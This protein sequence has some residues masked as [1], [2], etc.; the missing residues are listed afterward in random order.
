M[1][2]RIPTSGLVVALLSASF[3]LP[4]TA[5]AGNGGTPAPAP[6]A[7]GQVDPSFLLVTQH[8]LFVGGIL[9]I[10]G[11]AADAANHQVDI[12][13]RDATGAWQAVATTLA[14]GKG[15][16]ATAWEPQTSGEYE[17]RAAITGALASDTTTASASRTILVYKTARASW[18][19]PGFYGKHTACGQR[20]RRRTL[21]IANRRLP[22]GTQ[23][24]VTYRGRSMV[25]PVIDRG[26]YAHGIQWDLTAAV[27]RR[28]R[29]KVTSRIGVVP[30][31]LS[32]D[33][34]AL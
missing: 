9:E 29:V 25:V 14:D 30:M 24:A 32:L 34:P 22:C 18:Y 16:F 19:G 28:L 21:G 11:S 33:P 27:A 5:L 15:S 13:S 23:V 3:A 8:S 10:S 12:Q 4:A 2:P 20:L 26:P 1:N 7:N 17:L 31:N 6:V